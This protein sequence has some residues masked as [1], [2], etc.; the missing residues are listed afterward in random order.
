MR[1]SLRNNGNEDSEK[2]MFFKPNDSLHLVWVEG[3]VVYWQ[4]MS[5]PLVIGGEGSL[6]FIFEF[7]LEFFRAHKDSNLRY[8]QI[9]N[10]SQEE[11]GQLEVICSAIVKQR[12]TMYEHATEAGIERFLEIQSKRQNNPTI[13]GKMLGFRGFLD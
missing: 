12:K 4:R 1:T 9:L 8:A 7:D 6:P 5:S 2:L 13:F 10:I 11:W 3:N